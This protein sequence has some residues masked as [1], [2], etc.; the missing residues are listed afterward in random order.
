MKKQLVAI[1][2]VQCVFLFD[3]KA[4]RGFDLI[5]NFNLRSYSPRNYGLRDLVFKVKIKNMNLPDHLEIK[6]EDIFFEVYWLK[7]SGFSI[8]VMGMPDGFLEIKNRLKGFLYLNFKHVIPSQ[9]IGNF[10]GFEALLTTEGRE[11]FV[12]LSNPSGQENISKIEMVFGEKE[13][14]KSIKS[15]SPSGVVD[16]FF[17]IS[18]KIWSHNKWV[19]D[20]Q[21]YTAKT[22]Q[23]NYSVKLK[24]TYLAQGEFGFPSTIDIKEHIIFNRD[25]KTTT[26]ENKKATMMQNR[27]S[28]FDYEINSGRAQEHYKRVE[29][30]K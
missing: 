9:N 17:L 23:T 4:N 30:K 16:T 25:K 27:I 26:M 11:Q 21:S 6:E 19:H 10:N 22:G 1:I 15:T 29:S 20:E 8:E 12:V 2:I 3:L 28:F 5:N 7:G 18:P 14:L 13:N 24:I